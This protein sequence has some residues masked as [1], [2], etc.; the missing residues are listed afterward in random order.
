MT[1]WILSVQ[2]YPFLIERWFYFA[3]Q[4]DLCPLFFNLLLGFISEAIEASYCENGTM[5]SREQQ[6]KTVDNH[7]GDKQESWALPVPVPG[8]QQIVPDGQEGWW[9]RWWWWWWDWPSDQAYVE[10]LGGRI[11]SL[12]PR[13]E[14]CAGEVFNFLKSQS[15]PVGSVRLSPCAHR[16]SDRPHSGARRRI[17]GC[18]WRARG[19]ASKFD[20]GTVKL[21]R[22]RT[23]V[24]SRYPSKNYLWHLSSPAATSKHMI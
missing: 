8:R 14:F 15:H 3:H 20:R 22:Q 9:S 17:E 4:N 24:S 5:Q 21:E 23:G 10:R 19:A 18:V 1:V 6:Q 7:V 16:F 12:L 2:D 11:P 13:L